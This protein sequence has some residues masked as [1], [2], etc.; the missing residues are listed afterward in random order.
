METRTVTEAGIDLD[1]VVIAGLRGKGLIR[2]IRMPLML[3][4]AVWQAR[5]LLQANRPA[6]VVSFGGYAAAPGG[7]AAWTRG[8]PVLVHEQNR[9]PGLT[10]RLLARFSRRILQGFPGTFPPAMSPVDCGNP[11]RREVA[12]LP[13][14]Q[15]RFA[16]RTGPVRVLI[17]GGSQG[18]RVLNRVVPAALKILRLIPA[19][20]I[21]HQAGGKRVDE[22]LEAYAEAGVD[23][24]IKPFIRDMAEAYAWADLVICRSGAL[25]IAELAA[26]GVG[27]VLI[28]FAHAVD[29]HQT[30]NAEYLAD[31]KA[32]IILP[33]ASFDPQKLAATLEPLLSDR[34][35]LL[36]MANAARR[37]AIPDAA[38]KVVAACSEWVDA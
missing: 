17:T 2:W 30:R 23:A 15:N 5:R 4:R 1:L 22:A 16:G 3:L 26:A 6:C 19:I 32:A 14:P 27:S 18:A 21:R 29:D 38:E 37:L 8:V 24:E 10:N 35:L 36:S 12:A 33:Q 34:S 7:I 9:I 13:G 25:T 20:E 28:P 11:V 31:A